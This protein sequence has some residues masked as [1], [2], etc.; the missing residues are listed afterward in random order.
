MFLQHPV[1]SRERAPLGELFTGEIENAP[2][3]SVDEYVQRIG[4]ARLVGG[5]QFESLGRRI[6]VSLAEPNQQRPCD[7]P[8]DSLDVVG[9]PMES[10]AADL[11]IGVVG[12]TAPITQREATVVECGPLTARDP[13][14]QSD[15]APGSTQP[16]DNLECDAN[17]PLTVH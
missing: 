4:R 3:E 13:P 2:T 14:P 8:L 17:G 11:G 5:R 6:C 16:T 15:R 1:I 7:R 9:L 10:H 12:L